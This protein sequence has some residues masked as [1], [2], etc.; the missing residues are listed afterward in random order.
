M[1]S[2]SWVEVYRNGVQNA[3]IT[4]LAFEQFGST[5]ND[6]SRKKKDGSYNKL[7]IVN[8]TTNPLQIE[9]DGQTEK[10]TFLPTTGSYEI[11]PDDGEYFETVKITNA[12]STT[13]AANSISIQYA[14]CKPRV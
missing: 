11:Q 9:L 4:A 12:G 7:L 1:V 6:N 3:Q 8:T 10:T 14:I 2:Y 5:G 13:I